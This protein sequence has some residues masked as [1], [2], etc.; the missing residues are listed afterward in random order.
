MKSKTL[1][2]L[3]S[4]VIVLLVSAQA[5]AI[6]AFARSHNLPCS[7]C[8]TAFPSLNA[9]G[10]DFK[11][12]GYR[13]SPISMDKSDTMKSD[14][15]KGV[16]KLPIAVA[17]VSR[18]II[19]ND[20]GGAASSTTEVRAIHEAEVYVAGVF[21]QRLSGYVEYEA[22]GEDGFGAILGATALNY[23]ASDAVH[24]QLAYGSS[25]FADPYDTLADHRKMSYEHYNITNDTFTNNADN[26]GKLRHSRQQVSLFGRVIGNKL[27]YNFGIGG[28]TEDN[29]ASESS[30]T[31]ARLAYDIM[32][33]VMIGTFGMTGTCKTSMTAD[34]ATCDVGATVATQNRDFSRAGVDLQADI[35]QIRLTTAF[36]SVSDD[37]INS[38]VKAKNTDY[39]LQ[40]VYY[41]NAGGK[42]L[43]PLLRYQS[44]ENNDGNDVTRRLIAGITYYLQDNFKTTFE[45]GNDTA[46][47][48]GN[49]KSSSAVVQLEAAF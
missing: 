21:Y 10:R 48:A 29:I 49:D 46:V 4:A 18:P 9:F 40:G 27:F 5:E 17:I 28:L 12:N 39:Y 22:E 19:I 15:A 38:G 7:S 24:L 8:H 6:P 33:N 34:F 23:D 37:V 11:T 47:P 30:V 20:P 43:V 13:L 45:I 3:S 25:F 2:M 44:S 26:G 35:G 1:C 36:M 41:G 42:Q 14:F 32:P 16:D 31:F